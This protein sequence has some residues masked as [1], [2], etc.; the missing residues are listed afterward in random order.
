MNSF[1]QAK[2]ARSVAAGMLLGTALLHPFLWPLVLIGGALLLSVLH[3]TT[4]PRHGA[5]YGFLAGTVKAGIAINWFF[6][7]YPLDWMGLT[8]P[9]LQI[10]AIAIYWIPGALT[11]GAGVA[12]FGYVYVAVIK[13][14]TYLLRIVGAG[15]AWVAAEILGAVIFSI[16]T[17]GPGSMVQP[18]F[19]FGHTGYALVPHHLLFMIGAFGGVY[20][21]S[22]LVGTLAE[23]SRSITAS[24][25]YRMLL[26][27]VLVLI[28]TA[29]VPL[30]TFTSHTPALDVALVE[31]SWPIANS[32]SA[33]TAAER[34]RMLHE[35]A[36]AAAADT[37]DV[38]VLPEDV[39]LTHLVGDSVTTH[40]YLEQVFDAQDTIVIDTA[41]TT[42]DGDTR[43]RAY[44][45]DL[46]AG[47]VYEFDKQYLVPQGEYVPYVYAT[48]IRA[49]APEG[50]LRRSIDDTTYRPGVS[51]AT[52][53]MPPHVPA[54]LF[55]FESV[56]PVGAARAIGAR[57]H[58]PFIAHTVSHSW[59]HREPHTLWH[60]LDAMLKVQARF[61][62]VPIMQSANN[63]RAKIYTP[64]GTI[65]Y[66]EP[67]ASG[68][69][70]Q[71]MRYSL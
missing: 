5:W 29:L 46:R 57:A 25:N 66:P 27:A 45:Y 42:I 37:I 15:F 35:I 8:S 43:L 1:W 4:A 12:F 38:L 50:M 18:Y 31:A 51:Q 40:A 39:R 19:S 56:A 48:L 14:Q 69:N 9:L 47:A 2:W 41:R 52:L 34:G 32:P 62:G 3:D 71:L 13:Q 53:S 17:L 55:C 16:Y 44:I 33:P 11:L 59:F 7:A 68:A 67:V 60:Q 70:W 65:E 22:F 23:A 49:L 24:S 63:T 6:S 28:L 58:V 61:T 54:V 10:A 36:V 21:L 64:L 30:V 26:A 20:G